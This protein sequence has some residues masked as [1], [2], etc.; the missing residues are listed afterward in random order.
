MP[1]PMIEEFAY[2]F[3]GMYSS[4]TLRFNLAMQ[5]VNLDRTRHV[6]NAFTGYVPG[7]CVGYIAERITGKSGLMELCS[8]ISVLFNLLSEFPVKPDPT[9]AE[10]DEMYAKL[11]QN[12]PKKD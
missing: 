7:V 5:Y 4:D 8:S 12:S 10:I 6:F 11:R 3:A 2:A 9:P 1:P